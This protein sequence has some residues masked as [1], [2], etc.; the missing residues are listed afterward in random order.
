M[1]RHAGED[2]FNLLWGSLGRDVDLN[3]DVKSRS[4]RHC[5]HSRQR[6]LSR[7][8]VEGTGFHPQVRLLVYRQ[9]V[10]L[11]RQSSE[12]AYSLTHDLFSARGTRAKDMIQFTR[13]SLVRIRVHGEEISVTF[14]Y[15]F[16]QHLSV[17]RAAILGP[18]G[19]RDSAGI[20]ETDEL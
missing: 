2:M 19:C 9:T 14:P 1:L 12:G 20:R 7:R 10:G 18:S 13:A 6:S 5:L 4:W 3:V 11:F 15:A 16:S 8:R 17:V